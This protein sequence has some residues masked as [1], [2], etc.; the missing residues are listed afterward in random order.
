MM[1]QAGR[2]L[3]EIRQA[4]ELTTR[5]VDERSRAIA[6]ERES[7]L[8]IVSHG[9]LVQIEGGKTVPGI[10]KLFSL[11][12]IYGVPL[13]DLLSQYQ[14]DADD[15]T[16]YHLRNGR[17][18]THL[19]NFEE[20]DLHQQVDFPLRLNPGL[21]L[22]RT[23]LVHRMVETWGR[24]PLRMLK[25]LDIR[26]CRYGF[27]GYSDYTM[28][29]LIRP[30]SFVEIDETQKAA[31]PVLSATEFDRPVY[32]I[33][34]RT[35]YV[36]SWCEAEQSRLISIPHPLSPCKTRI[37]AYP[38]EAEIVGRVTAIAI[39]FFPAEKIAHHAAARG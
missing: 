37:F 35:G 4:L 3:R 6:T 12:A 30:G 8:Y 19:V 9:R 28:Y 11:A 7:R 16:A 17:T 31:K 15:I 33:Q 18:T 34:L 5:D 23:T 29:P 14:I 25:Y 13:S 10:H 26:N 36:C 32:F 21:S 38:S 1:E 39:R 24:I 22:D 27:I 2:R 20:P